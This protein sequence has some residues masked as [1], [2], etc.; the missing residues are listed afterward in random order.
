MI[1]LFPYKAKKSWKMTIV[2][3]FKNGNII[4]QSNISPG[5]TC[6]VSMKTRAISSPIVSIYSEVIP[7][8]L[9]VH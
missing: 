9:K 3:I 1:F 4:S 6:T 2:P 5:V 7:Q 8:V